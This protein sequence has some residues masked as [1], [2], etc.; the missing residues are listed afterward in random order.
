MITSNHLGR[1]FNSAVRFMLVILMCSIGTVAFSQKVAERNLETFKIVK[2]GSKYSEESLVKT[3][4]TAQLRFH[5][6]QNESNI[7]LLDDGSEIEIFPAS[8]LATMGLITD[9]QSYSKAYPEK[10]MKS[11]F[12]IAKGTILIEQ[13]P[14]I[15]SD[16]V[17]A[18]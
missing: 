17:L 5:R 13:R 10:Y 2:T 4:E 1:V 16:K 14:T 12:S 15:T 8:K 3:F 7:I 11:T 18:K 6:F 9:P